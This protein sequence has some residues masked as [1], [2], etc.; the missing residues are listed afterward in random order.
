MAKCTIVRPRDSSQGCQ[1][2]PM[3]YYCTTQN[4]TSCVLTTAALQTKGTITVP[5]MH[6]MSGKLLFNIRIPK[7]RNGIDLWI[8]WLTSV[9]SSNLVWI[10]LLEYPLVSSTRVTKSIVHVMNDFRMA[11]CNILLYK[12]RNVDRAWVRPDALQGRNG[13]IQQL[14]PLNDTF[15]TNGNIACEMKSMNWIDKI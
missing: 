10:L 15:Y 3:P 12:I 11:Q 1:S 8:R 5:F 7:G 6:F 9:H 2:K 4:G 14:Y 13:E